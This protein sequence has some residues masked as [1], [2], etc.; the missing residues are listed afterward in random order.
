MTGPT[1]CI[2]PTTAQGLALILHEL[3]TNA[4][5]YGALSQES[6]SVTICWT[7]TDTH[8]E[9]EWMER[10]GPPVAKPAARGFGTK[11]IESAL[12]SEA[13]NQVELDFAPS[14]VRCS[15]VLALASEP[16]P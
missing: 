3:A 14:G 12:L 9:L 11:L 16:I 1:A 15:L 10:D 13:G 6:G 5:K 8:V 4:V 7:V 2:E